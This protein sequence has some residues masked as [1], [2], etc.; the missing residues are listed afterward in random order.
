[1]SDNINTFLLI[2]G[3]SITC[4]DPKMYHLLMDTEGLPEKIAF[5]GSQ[6]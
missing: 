6:H 2:Y 1:M 3:V 5:I 4:L